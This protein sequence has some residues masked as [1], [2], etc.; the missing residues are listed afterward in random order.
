VTGSGVSGNDMPN[1]P[2]TAR[3]D[4]SPV[5]DRSLAALL[6]GN[7]LPPGANPELR[8]VA[9]VLAALTASP[10]GDELAGL[11]AARAEFRRRAVVPAHVRKSPRRRPGGLA[12]RLGAKAG[13]AAAIVVMGLGGAA[14]AAYAGV[15]P[16]SWQQLAHRT[17]GAPAHE[18]GHHGPARARAAVPRYRHPAYGTQPS[19]SLAGHESRHHAGTPHPA[20]PPAARPP[21]ARP[22]AHRG[23]LPERPA[24]HKVFDWPAPYRAVRPTLPRA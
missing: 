14:A 17:I 9:D 21:A 16:G 5:E 10:G 3:Q 11:A 4:V 15:L 20:G 8:P 2:W 6:D 23:W 22:F 1:F 18:T 24:A 7:G 19:G 13:A 12:S